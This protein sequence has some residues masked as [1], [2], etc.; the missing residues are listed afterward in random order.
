MSSLYDSFVLEEDGRLDD[1]V[2]ASFLN[3]NIRFAPRFHRVDSARAALE[4]MQ[5]RQFDLVI[6]MIRVGRMDVREFAAQAKQIAPDIPTV[7]LAYD[8]PELERLLPQLADSALDRIFVWQGNSELFLAI[9]KSCEDLRNVEPDVSNANVRVVLV[10]EDSPRFYS[11]FLPHIYTE[12]MQQVRNL[13]S[14]SLHHLDRVLRMRARPKILL[15]NNWEQAEEYLHRFQRNLLG[16]ISDASFQ[17]AGK[18]DSQAGFKL[19]RHARQLI[20]DLPIVMHSSEVG[21]REKA[22]LLNVAYIDKNSPRML[23]RLRSFMLHNM[24]FGPFTFR[25]PGGQ[26]VGR[27]DNLDDLERLLWEVPVKWPHICQAQVIIEVGLPTINSEPSRDRTSS[28]T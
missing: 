15:A 25:M 22:S 26:E 5:K 14:E 21:N 16:L 24:G 7:L 13:M 17:R 2:L 23:S 9:I 27:A 6:T 10:V 3:L 20:P 8:T 1:E 18:L 19:I 28:R 12:I 11:A 4:M